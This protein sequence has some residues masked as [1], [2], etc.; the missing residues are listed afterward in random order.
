MK[1]GT[2]YVDGELAIIPE[3]VIEDKEV[4]ADIR[5]MNVIRKVADE[6]HDMIK[7]T[8]DAP[9]NHSDKKMPVLDLKVWLDVENQA[10]NYIFYENPT[11][12]KLVIS[13]TSALPQNMKMKTLTQEVFRRLHNTKQSIMNE[14]KYDLL[15]SYMQKLKSSQYSENE[16]LTILKG[17]ISTYENIRRL[18]EEGKRPFFRPPETRG[19]D[20]KNNKN[21][22]NEWFKSK[23]GDENKFTAVMFVEATPQGELIKKLRDTEERYKIDE[24]KRIKFIEK[25]GNKLIDCIRISD[26]YRSNCKRETKCLACENKEEFSNC[27][28]ENIGYSIQCL[29]C[30]SRGIEKVYEGESSRNMYL[31]QIEH[32]K[33][34]ENNDPNSVLLRHVKAD[35]KNE[36]KNDVKFDMKLTGSFQTPLQRIINEGVG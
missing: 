8:V 14:F 31:R 12:S 11:K 20:R 22:K 7:F 2:D 27:R 13:K 17:G 25:C 21:K 26:P 6:V 5:T 28:K 30:K 3:K 24:T 15:N 36:D 9:S 34:Y 16:R 19:I 32:T 29:L 33:Q 18:E 4:S 23:S 10:I 1:P 35:H